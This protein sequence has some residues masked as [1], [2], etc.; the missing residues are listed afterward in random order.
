MAA[1]R[2]NDMLR[3]RYNNRRLEH[4]P[5]MSLLLDALAVV[6][7]GMAREVAQREGAPACGPNCFQWRMQ[8]IPATPL[9][10]LAVRLFVEHELAPANREALKPVFA[11]FCGGRA[12]LKAACPFLYNGFCSVY[13]VR[14][15]SCRRYVVYGQPCAIGEDAMR[16]RPHNVMLPPQDAL[17][18]ALRLTLPW[19]RERYALPQHMSPKEVQA[20]WSRVTTVLQG[21]PWASFAV[22]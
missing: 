3:Y 14:P 10:I 11:L 22:S 13:P 15:M 21:V 2:V 17:Q 5:G 6:D 12:A 16:T 18:A 7:C 20:F 1:C 8:P 4:M 19:Y 9:E